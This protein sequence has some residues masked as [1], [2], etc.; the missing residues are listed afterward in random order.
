[1]RVFVRNLLTAVSL[2]GLGAI[3]DNWFVQ[4]DKPRQNPRSIAEPRPAADM[5]EE[6]SLG[7]FPA[8]D[9]PGWTPVT[10]VGAPR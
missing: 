9:A 8:S 10:S 6:T 3:V 4:A 1:M 7:S 2:V 5:V